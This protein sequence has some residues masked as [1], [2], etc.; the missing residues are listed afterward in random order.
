M[1]AAERSTSVPHRFDPLAK[2][3]EKGV[4]QMSTETAS[5]SAAALRRKAGA[6]AIA[7]IVAVV[8]VLAMGAPAGAAPAPADPFRESQC[9]EVDEHTQF[10][11]SSFGTGRNSISHNPTGNYMFVGTSHF[12]MGWY[13]DG[14]LVQ[15]SEGFQHL[16][17]TWL[18]TSIHVDVSVGVS[19][20]TFGDTTCTVR[21]RRVVLDN[22][23]YIHNEY[24]IACS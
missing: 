5:R 2:R 7:L 6:M 20:S 12:A 1:F 18:N 22:N 14:V 23:N 10:C 9:Y 13:V 15:G 11:V 4:T 24:E 16:T 3:A 21:I 17:Q 8:L 19:E